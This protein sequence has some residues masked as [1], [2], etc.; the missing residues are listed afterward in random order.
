MDISE[1]EQKRREDKLEALK[2][3]RFKQQTLRAWR[4]VP[5]YGSTMI[6]FLVFGL[7]FLTL[8]IA[9]Y[10]MSDHVSE[11]QVKYEANCPDYN[12]TCTVD[13]TLG[14]NIAG[15][16]YFYYE[17]GNFYQNHRRYVQSVSYPQIRGKV[18]TNSS[19]ELSQCE[20]IFYNYQTGYNT[21]VDGTP[22][23]PYA[24]AAPCGLVAKSVF[25]DSYTL[26]SVKDTVKTNITFNS[27]NIAWK[28]DIE[29]FK[30]QPGD[31]EKTQWVN[32]EDCKSL[33]EFLIFSNRALHRLDEGCRLAYL[34]EA[35]CGLRP[36]PRGWGLPAYH[37]EQ[38]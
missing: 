33:S 3:N 25:N 37:S 8:G 12:T 14:A 7:I 20:P 29:K 32:I 24:V 30:N 5:S 13:F 22:L 38:L 31:W 4:P 23:D 21:S 9:L 36:R 11:A 18:L 1:E 34:Q 17:L 15:P 19:S 26:Y 27:N 10:V 6:I 2:N 35:V 16:V 28:T